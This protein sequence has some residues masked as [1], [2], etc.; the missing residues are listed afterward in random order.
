MPDHLSGGLVHETSTR[1]THLIAGALKGDSLA[2]QTDQDDISHVSAHVSR[3]RLKKK[4]DLVLVDDR[5]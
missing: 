5:T 2:S 4:C 1:P 3:L